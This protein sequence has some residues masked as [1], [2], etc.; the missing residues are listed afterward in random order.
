MM[1]V[2]RLQKFEGSITAQGK[3]LLHGPLMCVE[4]VSNIDRNSS[5]VAKPRELQVFLFEQSIIFSD[6]IGK[7]TQFTNPAYI[8]KNQ[9]QVKYPLSVERQL[10]RNEKKASGENFMEFNWLFN[11]FVLFL[12]LFLISQVNKMLMEELAENRLMLRSTDPLRPELS[13]IINTQTNEQLH[14]WMKAITDILQT[15]HDFLKAITSPIAYQKELT[16]ES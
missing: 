3:L 15:Q 7:K 8:Y 4:G 10:Y 13:Y 16:K 2:G 6:I 11:G 9:I 1:D 12:L 5:I 14:E